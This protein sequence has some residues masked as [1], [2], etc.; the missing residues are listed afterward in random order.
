MGSAFSPEAQLTE[1]TIR[2]PLAAAWK[3]CRHLVT[4]MR[5]AKREMRNNECRGI[6]RD[7]TGGSGAELIFL[8]RGRGD[9]E[10]SR[11]AGKWTYFGKTWG[12]RIRASLLLGESLAGGEVRGRFLPRAPMGRGRR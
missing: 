7:G 9:A 2:P 1:R 11:M 4:V 8:A 3:E 6:E 10:G 5:N 12:A